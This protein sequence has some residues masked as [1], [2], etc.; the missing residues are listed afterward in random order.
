MKIKKLFYLY[1]ILFSKNSVAYSIL[2]YEFF[3]V[4]FLPLNLLLGFIEKLF[5]KKQKNYNVPVIFVIGS[6]RSGCT[7][8]AQTLLRKLNVHGL[9]N[10]NN[11]F[12]KSSII[13][14]KLNKKIPNNYGEVKNYY[15]LTKNLL[16]VNDNYPVWDRWFGNEHDFIKKDNLIKTKGLNEYFSNIYSI[17]N[18][19]IL[20]KNGRNIFA[21]KELNNLFKRSLFIIVDRDI[22]K[23]I[24]STKNAKK[25]FFNNKYSW[26]LKLD[27]YEKNV[28]KQCLKI[29]NYINFNVKKLPKRKV[30]RIKYEEFLDKKKQKIIIRKIKKINEKI[31]C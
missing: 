23:I 7:Y 20:T 16:D 12:N 25:I 5:F 18:K 26:G 11:I 4:I 8:V 17:I 1:Q 30:F 28:E 24:N 6:H 10:L 14:S 29:I 19:P 9:N 21:I 27:H 31:F 15:G 13:V 3:R 22:E 2:I